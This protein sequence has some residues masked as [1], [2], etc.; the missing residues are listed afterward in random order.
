[1]WSARKPLT[2]I[3]TPLTG[4]I[5]KPLTLALSPFFIKSGEGQ[6]A[7]MQSLSTRLRGERLGEGCAGTRKMFA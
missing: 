4:I 5:N 2:G 6:L 7:Q 1:M 3:N